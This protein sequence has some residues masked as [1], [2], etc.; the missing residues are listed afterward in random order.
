MKEAVIHTDPETEYYFE[1]GCFI[2]ELL[3][4]PEDPKISIARARVEPGVSTVRHR[5]SGIEE[6]YVILKGRG[7]VDVGDLPPQT[8]VPGDVVQIPANCPQCITN[9]GDEDLIFLAICT[10]RFTSATYHTVNH[11][12]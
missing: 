7:R 9:V 5:L 11:E 2:L 3:N 12:I 8:V 4:T 6:R 10:P 1:E